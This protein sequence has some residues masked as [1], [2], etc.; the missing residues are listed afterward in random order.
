MRGSSVGS[1]DRV[2]TADCARSRETVRNRGESAE[3]A[4]AQI[5]PGARRVIDLPIRA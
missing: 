5:G 1:R 4:R 2:P 3:D